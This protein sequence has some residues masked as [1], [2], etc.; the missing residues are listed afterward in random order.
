MVE[1]EPWVIGLVAGLAALIL[2]L[3]C[4]LGIFCVLWARKDRQRRRDEREEQ[5]RQRL[6]ALA[7]RN[8]DFMGIESN[9]AS[10]AS[11]NNNANWVLKEKPH[12]LLSSPPTLTRAAGNEPF[13]VGKSMV[14]YSNELDRSNSLRPGTPQRY[15]SHNEA[16]QRMV[17][18]GMIPPRRDEFNGHF[19]AGYYTE[20]GRGKSQKGKAKSL[21]MDGSRRYSADPP[22]GVAMPRSVG[23]V[24]GNIPPG[25]LTVP[26][27]AKSPGKAKGGKRGSRDLEN[28]RFR[29]NSEVLVPVSEEVQLWSMEQSQPP[30][31]LPEEDYNTAGATWYLS[32]SNDTQGISSARSES[33]LYRPSQ[34]QNYPRHGPQTYN[35]QNVNGTAVSGSLPPEGPP[36][37][38]PGLM[39]QYYD[40]QDTTRLKRVKRVG[41][42]TLPN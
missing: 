26:G 7:S 5:R 32:P 31:T 9:S 41:V 12:D 36:P 34:P 27:K 24:N 14:K 21:D 40:G 25:Y 39:E 16:E 38:S 17:R 23:Y 30:F 1:A 20:P 11:S 8:S 2:V 29:H 10:M 37:T 22:Q 33:S 18:L 6:A 13:I 42:P 15:V 28:Q 4:I 19:P 35:T 3:I